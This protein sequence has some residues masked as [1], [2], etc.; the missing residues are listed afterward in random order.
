MNADILNMLKRLAVENR[1][2][3]CVG[4][5][6]EHNCG[7]HGCAVIKAA[8]EKIENPEKVAIAQIVFDEEEMREIAEE[9]VHELVDKLVSA[10]CSFCR[11]ETKMIWSYERFGYTA[12]CPVCGNTIDFCSNDPRSDTQN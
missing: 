11:N 7:I 2:T 12:F 5:G 10:K 9:C 1:S 3:A 4:C 8:M 6:Y